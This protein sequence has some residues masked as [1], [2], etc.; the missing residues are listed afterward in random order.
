M[1]FKEEEKPK[2]I[3]FRR[4]V[5][6]RA[7]GTVMP[8]A[9]SP[10]LRKRGFAQGAIVGRWSEIVGPTLSTQC[11]PERL[12]FPRDGQ[13]GGATLHIRAAGAMALELQHLAPIVIE[14]VNGFFGYA[15]VEKISLHQ[16]PVPTNKSKPPRPI[17]T[18]AAEETASLDA[19]V[20]NTAD[21]DLRAALRALGERVAQAQAQPK[22]GAPKMSSR[23]KR[24]T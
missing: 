7:L 19:A 5:G 16:G 2:D 3:A 8:K 18:L 4:S 10:V 9:A 1:A 21:P 20:A 12:V 15:A 6:P 17:R 24:G 13:A 14:R 11:I 22:A 23:V